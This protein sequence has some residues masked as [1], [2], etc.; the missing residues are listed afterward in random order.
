[1]TVDEL[2]EE[3]KKFEGA[4]PVA[5]ISATDGRRL[6][7]DVGLNAAVNHPDEMTGNGNRWHHQADHGEVD[8]T[9]EHVVVIF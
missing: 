8:I 1:M 6:D 3:L 9:G 2:R 4:L 5:I 7:L